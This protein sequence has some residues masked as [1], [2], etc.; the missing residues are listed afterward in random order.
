MKI[1]KPR[2]L[3]KNDRVGLVCPASRLHD[4]SAVEYAKVIIESMGLQPVIGKNVL[5]IRGFM[6]GSDEERLADLAEF[7]SDDSIAGIFCL[8]G[9]YGTLRLLDKLDYSLIAA[10]P[11]VVVGSD[12]N[13]SL[14]LALYARSGLVSFHGPNLDRVNTR[15]C[16]EQLK[17]AIMSAVPLPPILPGDTTYGDTNLPCAYAPVAGT[18]SGRLV[19]GNLTALVSL[20]GTP[21]QPPLVGSILFL[22]DRNERNDILDRW[23]TTL[24]VSGE[25]SRSSAV[26]FGQFENCGTKGSTNLSS[27]EDLFGDRLREL[28]KPCCFH[29]PVGQAAACRPI[30]IGI[31]AV[32]DTSAGRLEFVESALRSD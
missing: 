7:F 23:F 12:D 10:H 8:T 17:Q 27:L 31:E 19:G 9:G 5:S 18:A 29:L 32:V 2:A 21:F 3:K 6:A 11:K 24:F 1:V 28:A 14:L 22:E 16:I 26:L 30:P 15:S 4:P 13:T 20:M 25:L